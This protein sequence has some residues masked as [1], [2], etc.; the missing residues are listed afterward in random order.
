MLKITSEQSGDSARPDPGR[1]QR[2]VGDGTG[3]RTWQTVRRS[4][5][6][7]PSSNSPASHS[8]RRTARLLARMWREG[9]ALIA[10]GCCTKHIVGE[11]TGRDP[12]SA[13][14]AATRH[15]IGDTCVHCVA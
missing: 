5:M 14:A 11:I 2:A 7:A 12:V 4:G 9:A 6:F 10:H 8:F 13:S 15:R 1:Q 3:T